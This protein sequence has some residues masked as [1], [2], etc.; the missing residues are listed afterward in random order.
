MPETT[1]RLLDALSPA[2]RSIAGVV[3]IM[4]AIDGALPEGDGLKVFNHLYLTVTEAIEDDM[5]LDRWQSPRWMAHLDVEFAKLYFDAIRSYTTG[6]SD[7]P[8][9]WVEFFDRR[10]SPG[11]AKVQYGLAGIHAHINRDLA[12][13]V[14]RACERTE[15][16]PRRDSREHADYQRVNEILDA[17]EVRA[18]QRMATGTIRTVID[19]VT[20]LDRIVAIAVIRRARDVAWLRA[21]A[22]Y[23][24]GSHRARLDAPDKA[25]RAY[26]ADNAYKADQRWV[27]ALSRVLLLPT[28]RFGTLDRPPAP[29]AAQM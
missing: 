6:E 9:A 10:F 16:A 19:V 14:V 28:E 18:M 24:R 17:V 11:I 7:T 27:A 8:R 23:R 4:K 3:S 5:R 12:C 20:P 2:P 22:M 13:A 21:T 25:Q 15:C 1:N 29:V 26:K